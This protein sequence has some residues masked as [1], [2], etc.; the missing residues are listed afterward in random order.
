MIYAELNGRRREEEITSRRDQLLSYD[1]GS[2]G[3]TPASVSACML[4]YSQ[5]QMCPG[6]LC[7]TVIPT[8]LVHGNRSL[9]LLG[10]R[11]T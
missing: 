11:S 7:A 5:T 3:A 6:A 8:L 1:E 10:V 2:L 4:Q 9:L